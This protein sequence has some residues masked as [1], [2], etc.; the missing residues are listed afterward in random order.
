M[1]GD[2]RG[3]W[4]WVA[5]SYGPSCVSPLPL[6]LGQPP[7]AVGRVTPAL[8]MG[9]SESRVGPGS[10]PPAPRARELA[11]PQ[12]LL[13][14][15]DQL[16]RCL[17]GRALLPG[18]A[19]FEEARSRPFNHDARGH[20]AVIVQVQCAEDVIAAMRFYFAF[21]KPVS[22]A[23]ICFLYILSCGG[24]GRY[25]RSEWSSQHTQYEE[26]CVRHR[27]VSTRRRPSPVRPTHR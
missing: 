11:Q 18:E 26:R 14:S 25:L 12:E 5:S 1:I 20:P 2:S 16:R 13:L 8:A 10:S 7:P 9:A 24:I 3:W 15:L 22:D 6:S 23:L 21:G 17:R 19:G 4:W 27:P